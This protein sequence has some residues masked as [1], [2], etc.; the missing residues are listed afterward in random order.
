MALI[1]I[2]DKHPS[3]AVLVVAMGSGQWAADQTAGVAP[4]PNVL[5]VLVVAIN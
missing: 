5:V 3:K 2:R 1:I 4:S